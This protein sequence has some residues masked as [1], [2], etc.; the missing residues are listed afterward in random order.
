MLISPRVIDD[1]TALV[2]AEVNVGIIDVLGFSD[3]LTLLWTELCVGNSL[4]SGEAFS[5][6][7]SG[8]G[9]QW[10][11]SFDRTTRIS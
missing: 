8:L 9:A 3:V 4:V 1:K 2:L 10:I 6:G 11:K 7:F 5:T